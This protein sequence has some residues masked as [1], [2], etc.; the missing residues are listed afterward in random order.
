[1][2][3]HMEA[4][5]LANQR[6]TDGARFRR[7][8]AELSKAEGCETLAHMLVG[9]DGDMPPHVD[10]MAL[11]RCLSAIHRVGESKVRDIFRDAGMYRFDPKVRDLTARERRHIALALMRQARKGQEVRAAA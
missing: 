7:E 5:T 2:T 9:D 3:Q 11:R 1:M 8:L 6:R 4:L 10:G